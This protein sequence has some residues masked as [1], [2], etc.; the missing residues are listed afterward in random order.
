LM[1]NETC[2]VSSCNPLATYQTGCQSTLCWMPLLKS[3]IHGLSV[4]ASFL[5]PDMASA[6]LLDTASWRRHPN[7]LPA[8]KISH[9]V[10]QFHL[11]YVGTPQTH[12]HETTNRS[13]A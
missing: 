8:G 7:R 6:I 10:Y 13:P 9:D 1:R 2:T 3:V 11:L 4:L 12:Q 5:S